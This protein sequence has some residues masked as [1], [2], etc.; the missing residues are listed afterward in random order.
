MPRDRISRIINFLFRLTNV[1][2]S[3]YT[4]T[5]SPAIQ[6]YI[7]KRN[8]LN[9]LVIYSEE[10]KSIVKKWCVYTYIYNLSRPTS[11]TGI[12]VKTKELMKRNAIDWYYYFKIHSLFY[13]GIKWIFIEEFT[14]RFEERNNKIYSLCHNS[15]IL[16]CI[17][18]IYTTKE[19]FH[20][21]SKTVCC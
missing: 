13:W 8:P 11:Q 7:W 19:N 12:K 9:I 21:Y 18:A 6:I 5:N 20:D 1:F 15:M 17:C 16:Y 2:A 4:N 10:I 14:I 3:E